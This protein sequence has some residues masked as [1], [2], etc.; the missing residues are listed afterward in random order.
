M[1]YRRMSRSSSS[2]GIAN[3]RYVNKK[4]ATKSGSDTFTQVTVSNGHSSRSNCTRTGGTVALFV[5]GALDKLFKG[6]A[7]DLALRVE[8][9]V[10]RRVLFVEDVRA[11]VVQPDLEQFWLCR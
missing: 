2:C 10:V 6:G 1:L 4:A 8:D 5:G 3:E 7:L 11:R 9:E